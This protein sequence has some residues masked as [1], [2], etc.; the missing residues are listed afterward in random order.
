MRISRVCC[1]ITFA[2]ALAL[3]PPL[4][5]QGGSI[6]GTVINRATGAP[7]PS[8]Q[9]AV[10]GTA[11]GTLTDAGGRF[12]LADVPGTTAVLRVR[13]IGF[14]SVE[15]TVAVGALE[16]KIALDQKALE[17]EGPVV[18]GTPEATTQRALGNP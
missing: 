7:V 11:L 8:A 4:A 1:S 15:D 17:L 13:I 10:A 18:T 3:A 2:L 14:R 9:V 12:H 6:A 16:V 5:A